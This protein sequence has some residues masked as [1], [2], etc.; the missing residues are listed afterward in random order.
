MT[1]F[2]RSMQHLPNVLFCAPLQHLDCRKAYGIVTLSPYKAI[3][4]TCILSDNLC[5]LFSSLLLFVLFRA[6]HDIY[7]RIVHLGVARGCQGQIEGAAQLA[8][9]MAKIANRAS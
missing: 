9:Q 8:K 7:P 2:G 4:T 1:H 5:S 6:V 3:T